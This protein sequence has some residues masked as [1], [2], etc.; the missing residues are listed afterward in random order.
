MRVL[1]EWYRPRRGLFTEASPLRYLRKRVPGISGYPGRFVTIAS[2]LKDDIL[3]HLIKKRG[4]E[5]SEHSCGVNLEFRGR[6]WK[7]LNRVFLEPAH[8][9][10]D[11][12]KSVQRTKLLVKPEEIDPVDTI[13]RIQFDN[14]Q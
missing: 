10:L 6:M 8:E 5:G 11:L 12:K 4:K 14:Q 7:G 3:L 9:E 1:S 13:L 2:K